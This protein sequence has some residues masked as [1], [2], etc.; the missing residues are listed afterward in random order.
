MSKQ[1]SWSLQQDA[2]DL[3]ADDLQEATAG[4]EVG[5]SEGKIILVVAFLPST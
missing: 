3:P 4:Q 1:A 2:L 5:I